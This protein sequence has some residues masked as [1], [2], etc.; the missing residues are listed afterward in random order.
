MKSYACDA[1]ESFIHVEDFF[2]DGVHV[3]DQQRTFRPAQTVELLQAEY[4]K[5]VTPE[6]AAGCFKATGGS[7]F[8]LR[9]LVR[10]LRAD[11]I[12]PTASEAARV[13]Q[14]G[15]PVL[16]HRVESGLV[17]ALQR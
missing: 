10:A 15:P 7:P 6:F 16:R 14:Q 11:A 17:M 12:A 2:H 9:E 3:A 8:F 5:E 1:A 4:S 13:A